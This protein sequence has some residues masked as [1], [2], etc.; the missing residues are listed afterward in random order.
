MV[1]SK[2]ATL[3][4]LDALRRRADEAANYVDPSGSR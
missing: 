2:L 1:S 3:E 4:R